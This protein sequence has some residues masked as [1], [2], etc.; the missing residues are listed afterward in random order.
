MSP[1][2]RAASEKQLAL[3]GAPN[4]LRGQQLLDRLAFALV[5][6]EEKLVCRNAEIVLTP[7]VVE[8]WHKYRQRTPRLQVTTA[9]K[10]SR[11]IVGPYH[12]FHQHL[13]RGPYI[14]TNHLPV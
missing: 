3:S 11:K 4:R 7:S 8:R 5:A 2:N 10:T 12:R 9:T 13:G 1:H 14:W 6:Y